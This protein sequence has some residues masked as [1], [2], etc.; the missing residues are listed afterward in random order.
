MTTKEKAEF[1]VFTLLVLT[2]FSG[3]IAVGAVFSR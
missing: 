2:L 1:L 3:G